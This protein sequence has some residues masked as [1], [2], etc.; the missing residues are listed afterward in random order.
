MLILFETPAGLALFKVLKGGKIKKGDDLYKYFETPEKAAKFVQLH[1]FS[2]FKDTKEAIKTVNKLIEGDLT[3]K[4][5]KFLKKNSIIDEVQ[6]TIAV[7]DKTVAK[8]ITDQLG[9][10]CETGSKYRELTRGIRH[11]MEAL[12]TGLSAEEMQKMSLGLAHTVSRFKLKFSTDKVDQMIIQAVSLLE[13]LDKELNNYA[14]RLREWYGWH[15][16]ELERIV[17]ENTTYAKVVVAIGKKTQLK[18]G[19]IKLE[20]IVP[21]EIEEDIKKAA[22]ISMGS[23]ILDTDV[24]NISALATQVIDLADYR[25]TLNEYIATR[26]T[27]VAPNLTILVGDVLAAKLISN[28]GSLISL[29]KMPSSTIQILG[30]EK[31]LFRAMKTRSNTPKY[32]MIYNASLVGQASAK[33]KGRISRT[34]AAKCALCIRYDA[35][36]ENQDGQM[37]TSMKAYVEK[38]LETME[39]E[40]ARGLSQGTNQQGYAGQK[41]NR[42]YNQD[43]DFGGKRAKYD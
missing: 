21:E 22:E 42:D 31:A 23:D 38:R 1:A 39:S 8:A 30:A 24:L 17:T 14:M 4:A 43:G 19:T 29:A 32:G 41:R 16:P 20:D 3:K 15:F 18:E 13:D 2:R 34:L 33:Y 40:V 7:Y 6:E 11:Q 12:L 27:A 9:I 28:A 10:E 37:G 26:M 35:L 5:Q 25:A 36:G